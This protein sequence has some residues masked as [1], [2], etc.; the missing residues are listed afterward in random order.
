MS[1]P[2]KLNQKNVKV[3]L[4]KFEEKLKDDLAFQEQLDDI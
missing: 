3:E 2:F 4:N 1:Y